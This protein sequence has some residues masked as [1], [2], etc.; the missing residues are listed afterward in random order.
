MLCLRLS[1]APLST[2]ERFANAA[3][4]S[5]VKRQLISVGIAATATA[6]VTISF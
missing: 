3:N 2:I 4:A 6:L 5:L 1:L